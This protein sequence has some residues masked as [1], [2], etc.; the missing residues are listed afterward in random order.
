MFGVNIYR[1]IFFD[2]FFMSMALVLVAV[3]VGFVLV[4]FYADVWLSKLCFIGR[5]TN[6]KAK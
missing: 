3:V 2:S 1:S 6:G 5:K 4:F